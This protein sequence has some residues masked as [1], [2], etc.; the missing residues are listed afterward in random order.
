MSSSW[1]LL[2]ALVSP[3]S[4]LW[5]KFDFV[6]PWEGAW[7]SSGHTSYT[8][9]SA[10][11]GNGPPELSYGS[12]F[13]WSITNM[14]DI[15]G[16]GSED[17]VVGA[18]GE[19]SEYEDIVNGTLVS[20]RWLTGAIYVVFMDGSTG[21]A[22]S[23]VRISGLV[24]GGPKLYAN[25]DFGYSVACLG[26]L[27]GDGVPDVAVGAPGNF[28]SSVYVLFM[29][30]D[31]SVKDHNM[32]RGYYRGTIPASMT[33][34]TYDNTTYIPNGP[35]LVY[36]CRLGTTVTNIGD[37]DEDGVIDMAVTSL[38][39][40]GGGSYIY[41]MYMFP[42][43]S[44]KSYTNITSAGGFTSGGNVPDLEGRTH[45]SFGS[46]ILLFPDHDGDGVP[47]LV[48]GAKDLDDADTTNYKS[49]VVFFCFMNRNGTIREYH[50]ISELAEEG[51]KGGI[52][53]YT[54]DDAC[55]TAL[56]TIGDINQDAYKQQRPTLRSEHWNDPGY[57]DRIELNDL[58]VGCPQTSSGTMTGRIF[59]MYLTHQGRQQAHTVLPGS[60]DTPRGIGPG[61]QFGDTDAVGHSL[62]AMPDYDNNG[63][64][65][66]AVGAPGTSEN[67]T[68]SGAIYIWYLR[69]RRWH[70]FIPDTRAWLCS[71]IIPPSLFVFFCFASI[72]YFFYHFRRK[73][74]KI[75]MMVKEA[76]VE[77]ETSGNKKKKKREEKRK[78]REESKQIVPDEADDF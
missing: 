11:E 20:S 23:T 21:L 68:S 16:D 64:K 63:I 71:I 34:G 49:G 9:I 52:L 76:G 75:E 6:R 17:L 25:E 45:V 14:G 26:D 37:W 39:A 73:P 74:D 54:E 12:K 22:K 43:G 27:D 61:G 33:N 40:S 3:V 65:E 53:P 78:R 62:V 13:G 38:R 31:G 69:R 10:L 24:N 30:H 32:I 56:T 48:I 66:I 5:T 67:G 72:I 57:P 42:N 28:L 2:L 35:D 46:S 47:E 4:G 77:V 18:P 19:Y 8:K 15:D 55:G 36:Q 44:V 29:N 58:I 70:S 41:F 59:I 60:T 7:G 50:R 1:L 51:H